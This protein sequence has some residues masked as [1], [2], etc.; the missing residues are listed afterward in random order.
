MFQLTAGDVAILWKEDAKH[1]RLKFDLADSL[2]R[3]V[4]NNVPV[5]GIWLRD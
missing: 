1:P 2:R 4:E 5:P 3:P